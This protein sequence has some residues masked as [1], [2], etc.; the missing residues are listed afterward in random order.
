MLML[1]RHRQH[2]DACSTRGILRWTATSY[3]SALWSLRIILKRYPYK[4]QNKHK[5]NS[6]NFLTRQKFANWFFVEMENDPALKYFV[7][8]RG[9]FSLCR[10]VNMQNHLI[11]AKERPHAL[12]EIP[13][14]DVKDTAWSSFTVFLLSSHFPK[15]SNSFRWQMTDMHHFQGMKSFFTQKER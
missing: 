4:N 7:H 13:L 2:N 6:T 3:W 9:N 5:L 12:V 8:R 1:N 10:I 14:Q 11:W 15:I